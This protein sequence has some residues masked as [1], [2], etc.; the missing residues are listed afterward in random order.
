MKRIPIAAAGLTALLA[1]TACSSSGSGSPAA[2]TAAAPPAVVSSAAAP[3]A[4]VPA[5]SAPA[6]AGGSS[7]ATTPSAAAATIT[8]KNFGF[9]GTLTVKPGEK[10]KVVNEDSVAHTLTD[11]KTHKFDTGNV[12]GSGGTGTFTAPTTPGSYPFGCDYHPEMAG[13]LVVKA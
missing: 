8:I 10:V 2:S 5:A 12:D 11:K 13:T 1:L 3:V 4:S 6:A 9:T 7:P